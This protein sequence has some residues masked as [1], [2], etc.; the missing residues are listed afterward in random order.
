MGPAEC[1]GVNVKCPYRLMCLNIHSLASDA[2][3]RRS[4]DISDAGSSWLLLLS[5]LH[6]RFSV[7]FAV[8][9]FL[10]PSDT[11][12]SEGTAVCLAAFEEVPCLFPVEGS[13]D[14]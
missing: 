2:V 5:D 7:A 10:W 12:L 14:L 9:I 4:K 3:R 6:L 13:A 11:L 1:C 8:Y